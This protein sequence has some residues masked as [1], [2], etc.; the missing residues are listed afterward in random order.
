MHPMQARRF[1]YASLIVVVSTVCL[2]CQFPS[3]GS[4]IS[5]TATAL[6][7]CF[8]SFTGVRYV[9]VVN[10]STARR[11]LQ[12]SIRYLVRMLL[13]TSEQQTYF[14]SFNSRNLVLLTWFGG[15]RVPSAHRFVGETGNRLSTASPSVDGSSNNAGSRSTTATRLG[16]SPRSVRRYH[17]HRRCDFVF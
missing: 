6:L 2:L 11:R 9:N 5:E 12:P 10:S 1:H 4:S 17:C 3:S 16:D 7:V 14:K 15:C 13:T 8:P